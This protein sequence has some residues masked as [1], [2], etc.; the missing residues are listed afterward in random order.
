MPEP[1][2]G[3]VVFGPGKLYVAPLGTT[4]PAKHNDALDAA[5]DRIG[6]TEDGYELRGTSSTTEIRVAEE[7]V[8]IANVVDG[9]TEGVAFAFAELTGANLQR[10]FNGGTLTTYT[11]GVKYTPPA[12]G[13]ATR[14]MLLWESDEVD[15]RW[16]W[17]KVFQIGAVTIPRKRNAKAMIPV[18]FRV[19]V[20]A[21][22]DRFSVFLATARA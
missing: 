22:T 1:N 3:A 19:E 13:V 16:L 6:Y 18:E 14:R 10:A 11:G 9:T 5:W 17:P 15:E 7:T 2:A 12:P 8:P 4:P 21:G 20:P